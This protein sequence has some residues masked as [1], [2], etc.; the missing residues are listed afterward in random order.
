MQ[1]Q[2]PTCSRTYF[3]NVETFCADCGA[4]LPLAAPVSVGGA[5]AAQPAL[6]YVTPP[7][8]IGSPASRGT[9][10]AA[11]SIDIAILIVIGMFDIVPLLGQYLFALLSAAFVLFRDMNGAS[12]GKSM[13]GCRVVSKNG[14]PATTKQKMLRNVIFVLPDLAALIPFLGIF[15]GPI[16]FVTLACLELF[17]LL[18]TGERIGDKMAGTMVVKRR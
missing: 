6:S 4:R 8:T 5:V 9:R 18:V 1:I 16:G 2:C 14:T 15:L 3:N 17:V 7:E 10:I 13:L 11:F 12:F